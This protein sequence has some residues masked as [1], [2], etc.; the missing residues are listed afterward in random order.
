MGPQLCSCGNEM[1]KAV[2][3]GRDTASMGPQLCS[4]GNVGGR[5]RGGYA[6]QCFNGAATLQ[7]R[8]L[9]AQHLLDNVVML[10]SMGPQLCSCGNEPTCHKYVA[11]PPASMGPQLCSCGNRRCMLG[12][13]AVMHASMG[14]QLCSCGNL[15]TIKVAAPLRLTCQAGFNGAATLQLRK[16]ERTWKILVSRL[17]SMGPQLCS[18][19]N[20]GSNCKV[21]RGHPPR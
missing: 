14:P 15:T 18:C 17:A 8:K 16:H 20:W 1:C 2:D 9:I 13:R 11:R 6:A 5:G 19:G 3:V 21:G 4:C 12:I 7:L 10:A